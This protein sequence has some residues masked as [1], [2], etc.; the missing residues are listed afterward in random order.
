LL[1]LDWH[2][3]NA[4]VEPTGALV[5]VQSQFMSP[6]RV[7]LPNAAWILTTVAFYSFCIGENNPAV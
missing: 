3:G 1:D 2:L 6:E 5:G 7:R 4:S